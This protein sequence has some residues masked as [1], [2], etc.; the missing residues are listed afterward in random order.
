MEQVEEHRQAHDEHELGAE[1]AR[2]ESAE[3]PGETPAFRQKRFD[4]LDVHRGFRPEATQIG[5][6]A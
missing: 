3:G 5:Q 6:P 1:A 2:Q 4:R